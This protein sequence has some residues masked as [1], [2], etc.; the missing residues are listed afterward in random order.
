LPKKKNEKEKKTKGTRMLSYYFNRRN[1]HWTRFRGTSIKYP[2]LVHHMG[3]VGASPVFKADYFFPIK[4]SFPTVF[5]GWI[6]ALLFVALGP[7]L[8][9]S[10]SPTGSRQDNP[11]VPVSNHI[12]QSKESA[13]F[14][15]GED[16]NPSCIN[17]R[18]SE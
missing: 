13:N 6:A 15:V 16:E 17:M 14:C 1:W 12:A 7:S 2:I 4:E 3:A 8:F 9:S 18:Y 5:T 10:C 11:P